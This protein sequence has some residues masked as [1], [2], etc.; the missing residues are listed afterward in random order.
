MPARIRI[1]IVEDHP[2]VMQAV[3][4]QLK[5]IPDFSVVLELSHG[6]RLIAALRRRPVDLV[7]MDLG[8]DVGVFDPVTTL[9]QLREIFP[10][11]RVLV[12]SSFAYGEAVMGVLRV[13]VHGYVNKNDLLS[14]DLSRVI[15]RVLSGERVYSPAIQ[16]MLAIKEES[17][18]DGDLLEPEEREMLNLAA[19]GHTN[20]QIGFLMGY[21]EKTVRNRFTPI[22]R[23]LG[24]AN[25]VDAIRR[26]QALGLLA[27]G[28][29]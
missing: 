20:R 9:R 11:V 14:L 17:V 29:A 4:H 23:K 15:R 24:A 6:S 8:M 1:A 28:P 12:M 21:S 3:T 22:F 26:A 7:L 19:R 13:G 10:E 2:L 25:R 18:S 16:E 27:E 5:E